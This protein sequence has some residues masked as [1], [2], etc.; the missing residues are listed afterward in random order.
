MINCICKIEINQKVGTGFFCRISY[1]DNIKVLMTNYEILNENYINENDSLTLIVGGSRKYSIY[2]VLDLKI[3]RRTYFSKKYDL[4]IIEL[5]KDDNIYN[6]LELDFNLFEKEI[7][8]YKDISIYIPQYSS[9]NNTIVSYG[10][11]KE[12]NNYEIKHT[13]SIE[14]YSSGS[15]ILNLSKNIVIGIQTQNVLNKNINFGI[16]LQFPLKE[17]LKSD[18][19]KENLIRLDSLFDRLKS[20]KE[21][22]YMKLN[23][24]LNHITYTFYP[25]KPGPRVN[26]IFITTQGATT[27]LLFSYGTEINQMLKIY[28]RVVGKRD[29]IEVS[30]N[31]I[32]FMY[33]ASRIDFGNKTPVEKFFKGATLPKVIV[34]DIHN[35]GCSY[36]IFSELEK[37]ENDLIES[38]RTFV[39][40]MVI[41][42]SKFEM[43]NEDLEKEITIKFNNCGNI[44]EIKLDK[45][46]MVAE[47]IN[48]YFIKTKS[49]NGTFK[50]KGNIL[51]PIDTS[52]LDEAGLM[53]NSEIIVEK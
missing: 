5:N 26:V 38:Y 18:P 9:E 17:F 49:L 11:L 45:S 37:A 6:F 43:K 46:S 39:R 33:N 40:K 22:L 3:K 21:S 28:L 30:N 48:E 2:L 34:N 10:L 52:A 7:N 1:E 25:I 31:G 51:S 4:T 47:L 24:I 15:P 29:L 12:I 14:N 41:P 19:K 36:D 27:N 44:I 8:D 35:L 13:C 16:F 20:R 23:H 32:C 50:F 53:D 42:P